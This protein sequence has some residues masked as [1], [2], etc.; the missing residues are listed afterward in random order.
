MVGLALSEREC[1]SKEA[2]IG[3]ILDTSYARKA[4]KFM[5]KVYKGNKNALRASREDLNKAVDRYFNMPGYKSPETARDILHRLENVQMHRHTRNKRFFDILKSREEPDSIVPKYISGSYRSPLYSPMMSDIKAVK[6]NPAEH[7]AD[8]FINKWVAKKPTIGG[9]INT[10]QA[11]KILK[12]M[13]PDTQ[14]TARRKALSSVVDRGFSLDNMRRILSH[15]SEIAR[16]KRKRH[17]DFADRMIKLSP[18]SIDPGKRIVTPQE[19]RYNDLGSF[20]NWDSIM[21]TK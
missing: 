9:I 18:S 1:L 21:G 8:D 13:G 2:G 20:S 11:R 19:Q 15:E 4:L 17:L 3:N 10:Q 14:L 16:L 7:A 5:G 6:A 12:E